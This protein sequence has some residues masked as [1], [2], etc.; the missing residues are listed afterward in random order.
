MTVAELIE[1]L[2]EQP[3]DLDVLADGCD[4]YGEATDV[5]LLKGEGAWG[6]DT[7]LV[8]RDGPSHD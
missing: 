4:C 7:V 6:R 3:Q 5:R 2:K 8:A 1:K